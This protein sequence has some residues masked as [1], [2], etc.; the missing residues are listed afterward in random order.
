MVNYDSI[1]RLIKQEE[2]LENVINAYIIYLENTKNDN[3]VYCLKDIIKYIKKTINNKVEIQNYC[4][5]LYEKISKK[6]ININHNEYVLMLKYFLEESCLSKKWNI[7]NCCSL[8]QQYRI[9]YSL[10]K[11][12][13]ILD[14]LNKKGINLAL[15]TNKDRNYNLKTN[16]LER[17]VINL[18]VANYQQRKSM[19]NLLSYVLKEFNNLNINN[20]IIKNLINI[21]NVYP[22]GFLMLTKDIR[23]KLNKNIYE[24][25]IK[26]KKYNLNTESY[27]ILNSLDIAA[28]GFLKNNFFYSPQ[29]INCNN[30]ED[31]RKFFIKNESL[32][33]IINDYLLIKISKAKIP[34][35]KKF[36]LDLAIEEKKGIKSIK[37][38][39]KI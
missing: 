17:C 19:F 26:N 27:I 35:N 14:K 37:Y 6:L 12:S 38:C 25:K 1:S 13:N 3:I 4:D 39:K 24:K 29:G 31:F 36:W 28:K 32:K 7:L 34:K 15:Y 11:E 23:N 22:Q 5:F 18:L 2:V 30:I 33:D 10:L 16:L 21:K 20:K 8:E 9:I